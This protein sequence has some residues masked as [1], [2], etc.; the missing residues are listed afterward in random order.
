MDYFEW[1]EQRELA[2]QLLADGRLSDWEIAEKCGICRAT[3]YNWRQA[4]EFARRVTEHLAVF[5][6]EVHR[7]GLASRDRRVKRQNDHW[8]RLQAVIEKRADEY[9][10][11]HEKHTTDPKGNPPIHPA[12]LTGL[13]VWT[14]DGW[15]VDTALLRE[16]RA[17]EQHAAKELGQWSEKHEF[18]F[19]NLSDEEI[20]AR[21]A[22]IVGGGG[23]PGSDPA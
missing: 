15:E 10:K 3:L 11:A 20:I 18:D 14:E 16:L 23:S 9:A 2:A 19:S 7:R 4:P 12:A 21:A 1:T 5:R 8:N 22:S 13:L 6:D 17:L